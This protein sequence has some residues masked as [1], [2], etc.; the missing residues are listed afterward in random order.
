MNFKNL[1]LS[2]RCRRVWSSRP[3][4][5]A[6]TARRLRRAWAQRPARASRRVGRAR[7]PRTARR[8]GRSGPRPRHTVP[9]VL[10][11]RGCVLRGRQRF[12][13][14][15]RKSD[16]TAHVIRD[17]KQTDRDQ[18]FK[19]LKT[20]PPPTSSRKM[21]SNNKQKPLPKIFVPKIH[22]IYAIVDERVNKNELCQ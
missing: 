3:T 1:Q 7:R 12:C 16:Q 11:P 13:C 17:Q 14:A 10:W 20:Q 2:R 9:E 15:G 21:D 5:I 19:F 22:N 8:L 6:R 18:L 4:R